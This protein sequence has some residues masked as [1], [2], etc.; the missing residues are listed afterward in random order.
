MRRT[1]APLL[2]IVLAVVV[3]TAAGAKG[4]LARVDIS[5][6]RPEGGS[7][8]VR[9][10]FNASDIDRML[11]SGVLDDR[12]HESLKE[13]GLVPSE[14][15][16]RYL[17]SYRFEFGAGSDSQEIT[18]HL[19]PYATGGPVTYTPRGQKQTGEEDLTG[20]GMSVPIP[21]GW[22]QT[23]PRFL[24]YLAENGLPASNPVAGSSAD[25]PQTPASATRPTS[26]SVPWVWIM[27]GLSTVGAMS[28]AA[29]AVRR[30]VIA[31]VNQ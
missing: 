25:E 3:G 8:T 11:E 22:Y 12:K 23:K 17:V 26:R 19:Y 30:R 18:Q 10:G 2:G 29:R 7:V 4:I 5:G 24:A 31:G 9:M 27:I 1:W 15:G 28:L 13:L 14:L 16:P 6:P 20:M 21:S